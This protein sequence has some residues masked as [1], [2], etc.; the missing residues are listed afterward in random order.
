LHFGEV[1]V[2]NFPFGA[3]PFRDVTPAGDVLFGR[4]SLAMLPLEIA[5]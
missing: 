3:V 1:S 2:V 5:L 4:V